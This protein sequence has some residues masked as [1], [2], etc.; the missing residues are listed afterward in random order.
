[1]ADPRV[2]V[3]VQHHPSRTESLNRL[4]ST[5]EVDAVVVDPDPGGR[6][7]AWRTYRE[8]LRWLP[9]D[10]SHLLILQD[11]VI[12]CPGLRRAAEAAA[13]ARPGRL[14]SFWQGRAPSDTARRLV[15]A[16]QAGAP[17]CEVERKRWINTVALMWPA[18]LVAP[19]VEW[20]D[21]LPGHWR[22]DDSIVGEWAGMVNDYG[23]LVTVPSLVEHLDDVRSLV[24]AYQGHHTKRTAQCFIGDVPVDE[25]IALL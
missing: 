7:S 4:L 12:A 9:S 3:A 16:S 19:F 24:G 22:A 11:D 21:Q 1:M 17:F 25:W 8:C 14:I 23:C 20:A 18:P 10:A 5:T 6:S 13:Q 2:A 15:A